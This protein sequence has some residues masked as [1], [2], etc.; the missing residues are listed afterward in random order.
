VSE[1]ELLYF[2]LGA[3]QFEFG[4][5]ELNFE[6]AHPC[7]HRLGALGDVGHTF[8][9]GMVQRGQQQTTSRLG[10]HV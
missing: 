6:P 4:A 7:H 9:L 3:F 10:V 8:A 2:F 1:Q 5:I